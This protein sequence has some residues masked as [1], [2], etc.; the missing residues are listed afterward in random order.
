MKQIEDKQEGFRTTIGSIYLESYLHQGLYRD[1]PELK[2]FGMLLMH[3]N[4]SMT[5]YRTDNG[6]V[7]DIKPSNRHLL[8]GTA[9]Y[10][11]PISKACWL[12]IARAVAIELDGEFMPGEFEPSS[13]LEN[14]C[15]EYITV[16][17]SHLSKHYEV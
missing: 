12:C 11:D 14:E 5:F 17:V 13:A 6:I 9:N 16:F 4:D 1:N 10:G 8:L 15:G 2:R 3:E 7:I